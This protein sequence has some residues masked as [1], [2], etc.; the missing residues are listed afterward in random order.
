MDM[1]VL[2]CL[3]LV[4]QSSNTLLLIIFDSYD[5]MSMYIP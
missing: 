1:I 2:T 4:A 3:N 5:W